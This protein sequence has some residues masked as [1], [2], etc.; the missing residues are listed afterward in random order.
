MLYIAIMDNLQVTSPPNTPK[1]IPIDKLIS[2]SEQ[3]LSGPQIAKQVGCDPS[4]VYQRFQS[5]GYTYNRLRDISSTKTIMLSLLQAK[6]LQSINDDEIK[7]A[8][9]QTKI[10]SI[11]VLQDKIND[12]E[13][14]AMAQVVEDC[15]MDDLN[16]QFQRIAARSPVVI[17][18]IL[19]IV[20]SLPADIRD[21]VAKM[22]PQSLSS[23]SIIEGEVSC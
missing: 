9:V 19:N 13:R 11:G 16:S 20:G 2:L 21:R 3:G 18:N 15:T 5:V 12:L 4:N 10:W 6:F 23:G 1:Y 14:R 8:P 7:K 17:N 22:M